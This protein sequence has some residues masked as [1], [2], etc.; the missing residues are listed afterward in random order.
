MPL[1]NERAITAFNVLL[2]EIRERREESG[3]MEKV[4]PEISAIIN[5]R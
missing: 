1:I 5:E 3:D 4:Y 2:R